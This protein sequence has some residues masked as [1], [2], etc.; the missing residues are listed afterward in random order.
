MRKPSKII[1][2]ILILLCSSMVMAAFPL[3]T[4]DNES[5][6]A[7]LSTG[8]R[9]FVDMGFSVDAGLSNSYFSLDTLLSPE[10]TLDINAIH[11]DLGD[12]D[13][14]L[15]L[16]VG[17][18]FFTVISAADVSAGGYANVSGIASTGIPNSVFDVLANGI[19]SGDNIEGTGSVYGRIFGKVGLY[20]GYRWEDWQF[21]AK[22]GAFLPLA[23]SDADGSY[24]YS[25]DTNTN[26]DINASANLNMP[27]Y[28]MF[29]ID[30]MNGSWIASLSQN[31]GY[32]FDLGAIKM[33]EDKAMYGFSITGITLSPALMDY[34]TTVTA[35]ASAVI[36]NPLTNFDAEN[37]EDLITQTT[38][39]PET[40]TT[41][42]SYEVYMPLSIGGFYRLE[43]YPAFID[44]IGHGK[45]I[46]DNEELLLGGGI[47][48]QGASFPFNW[49]S[50]GLEYDR[51]MWQSTLGV[52]FD[53]RVIE[54]GVDV[55]LANTRFVKIF[56][57][58]GLYANVFMSMGY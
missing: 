49:L 29:D 22:M 48:A 51:V 57:D 37:E 20:G 44:W 8:S 50:M 43:G 7:L 18:D 55:G 21:G 26:G 3:Q 54:F 9:K 35:S 53:V 58:N 1:L 14:K 6:P 56:S 42:G 25:L 47:A 15:A 27:F 34:K 41:K 10:L 40:T 36:T 30:N 11:A 38:T 5:N 32:H 13:L 17:M 46:Y 4:Y 45:L 16:K 2:L 28:S 12:Q 24:S 31:V 52:R 19:S 39:E 33:K 23:V